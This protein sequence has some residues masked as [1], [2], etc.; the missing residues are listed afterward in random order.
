[1]FFPC[2]KFFTNI[3]LILKSPFHGQRWNSLLDRAQLTS[4]TPPAS[5]LTRCHCHPATGLSQN[6]VKSAEVSPTLGFLHVMSLLPG[7]VFFPFTWDCSF[8]LSGLSQYVIF[9]KSFKSHPIWKEAALPQYPAAWS[10]ISSQHLKP[11]VIRRW[12]PCLLAY[13]V[14][15]DKT[16]S[17]MRPSLCFIY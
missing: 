12:L 17:S 16:V 14:F 1:M 15:P 8:N 4:P 11:Q 2:L 13:L 5:P 6:L 3:Q 7:T 9:S 10:M